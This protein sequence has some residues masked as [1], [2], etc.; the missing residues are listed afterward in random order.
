MWIKKI[1]RQYGGDGFQRLICW[2][3]RITNLRDRFILFTGTPTKKNKVNIHYWNEKPNIG[4]AISP[5]I[6]RYAASQH[7]ISMDQR[8]N[9]MSHLYAVGSVVTAGCHDCTIWGSGILNT[10][11]LYRLKG[12][13]LDVRSVRGPLT[14]MV[15]MEH[16]HQVPEIYGDPAIL[17]PAIYNPEVQKE[18]D[19]SI[20][21]HMDELWSNPENRYHSISIC[22][23]DY[24]SFVQEIKKSKLIVSSSLHGI[25]FAEAYGVPAI[26]LKPKTDLFKY[27]DYYY[28]T[29]RYNFP[30]AENIQ[31]A[32]GM[33]IPDVPN[34]TE[35]RR[36]VLEAFPVDLWNKNQV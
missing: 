16:G 12:R 23:D 9:K 17:M 21:T 27:Y 33:D 26:L 22:S 13:T 31:D 30:I 36:Q 1:I 28:A 18:Y 7:G 15:L 25:I 35:M 4:D 29:N 8:I 24:E 2:F 34:F 5:V 6:V 3:L 20:I 19:V 11:I 10:K 32:L 14:R